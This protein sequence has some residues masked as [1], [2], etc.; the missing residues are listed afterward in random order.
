VN[1]IIAVGM[2]ANLA[3]SDADLRGVAYPG[4]AIVQ[5]KSRNVIH[6]F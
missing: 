4:I 3:L 2:E 1:V 6:S 5:L